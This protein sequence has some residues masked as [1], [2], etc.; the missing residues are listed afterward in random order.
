MAGPAPSSLL[1]RRVAWERLDG[2]GL[3]RLVAAALRA[4]SRQLTVCRFCGG[5]FPPELRI[6]TDVCYGCAERELGI[7]F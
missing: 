5:R 6:D 3:E 7:V 4:R 2:R 1:W